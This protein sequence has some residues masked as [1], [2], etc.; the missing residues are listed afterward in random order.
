[1][2]GRVLLRDAGNLL[3]MKPN[4]IPEYAKELGV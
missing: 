3:S 4:R 2:S 1:L